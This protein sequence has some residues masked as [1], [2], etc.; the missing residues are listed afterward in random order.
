M[1][2]EKNMSSWEYFKRFYLRD[3]NMFNNFKHSKLDFPA[4]KNYSL[5][6]ILLYC[7]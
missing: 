4:Q 7:Y 5:D 2:D 1:C 6:Q 3:L